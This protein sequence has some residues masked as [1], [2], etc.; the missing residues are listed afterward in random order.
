MDP[1]SPTTT[2]ETS[3]QSTMNSL[4]SDPILQTKSSHML[5]LQLTQAL[6]EYCNKVPLWPTIHPE[7]LDYKAKIDI[8][9]DLVKAQSNNETLKNY[10]LLGSFLAHNNHDFCGDSKSHMVTTFLYGYFGEESNAIAYLSNVSPYQIAHL[11]RFDQ[12][13]IILT[14][15]QPV[16]EPSPSP[17]PKLGENYYGSD[18]ETLHSSESVASPSNIHLRTSKL[19]YSMPSMLLPRH[20]ANLQMHE[21][22]VYDHGKSPAKFEEN[23][24]RHS[25]SSPFQ[26]QHSRCLSLPSTIQPLQPPWGNVTHVTTIGPSPRNIAIF[27]NSIFS[28]CLGYVACPCYSIMKSVNSAWNLKWDLSAC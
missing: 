18:R 11:S 15:P 2:T 8:N 27:N 20:S 1:S 5:K 24:C 23:P 6:S 21:D 16:V 28:N 4:P 26:F 7:D 22:E 13:T 17:E 9:L 14:K 19:W 12:T 3:L 10:Y 25:P